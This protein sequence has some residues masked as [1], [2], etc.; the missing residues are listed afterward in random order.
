MGT[1]TLEYR[2]I[3]FADVVGQKHIKP[4]LKAMVKSGSMPP[5]MIF[6]GS[7]GTGKTTSARILAAALNCAQTDGD[8]CGQCP[9]CKSVQLTNSL[10]VLEV[11]AASNGGVDEIRK[12]RELCQYAHEGDWRLILLDEA[13]SMSREAFN[14][15]LKILEEPPP[16][17]LF[18]L[19][20]TETDKI[21]ET[22]RSRSM[23][24][25]FRRL[26]QEDIVSR[27]RHIATEEDIKASDGLLEEI[28]ARV[29][30]GM[31]DA[32][33]L[34]DQVRRVG[35]SD[36]D[37]FRDLF[38]IDDVSE[39]LLAAALAGDNAAGSQVIGDQYKR[40][41]DAQA[42]TN[43]L[44]LLVRDLLVIK[45]G[46]Q[47]ETTQDKLASRTELAK[48]FETPQLTAVIKVLWELKSRTRAFETDQRAAME[49]AFVLISEAVRPRK[50]REGASGANWG[51]RVA[52]E[53]QELSLDQVKDLLA[54]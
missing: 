4:I 48:S 30:G 37:G 14:G 28:S 23:M 43:D 42:M 9:S 46:G 12:I 3:R 17:T 53:R 20:T 2:P 8:A 49:M 19:L 50:S 36:E 39:K 29:Q 33:M 51:A 35:I 40:T 44:V 45:S 47:P 41:G 38:G 32:V 26:S 16:H 54:S 27:L 21:L 10:S 24:F 25:E 7:R 11:D 6:G 5:A 31:R 34:L 1:L 52:P 18:V 13:H 15:L 22:V